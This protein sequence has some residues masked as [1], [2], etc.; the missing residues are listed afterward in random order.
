M[1]TVRELRWPEDRAALL[2]LDTSFTTDRV[3]R[4]VA[5]ELSFALDATAIDPPLSKRYDL[6]AD[7][8]ELHGL[9]HVAVA[10]VD[11][12]LAGML[13][14]KHE[15]WNG[16]AVVWHLY[17]SPAAR[18][19]GV[20]RALL[21]EATVVAQGWQAH[22]LWLETQDVNYGAIR[23]YLR[24]GFQWCGLDLALYDPRGP[25]AGDTALFFVRRLLTAPAA[26]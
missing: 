19:R 18:G 17:V 26:L 2:A 14:L 20:G 13:A 23:F 16:R 8:E 3:F 7:I 11:G 15:R 9:D 25:V 22:C 5:A 21:D 12:H 1:I 6:S 24:M 10:E 4:V